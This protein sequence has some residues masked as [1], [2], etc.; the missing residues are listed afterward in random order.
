MKGGHS[1]P[2][3]G[4]ISCR[5]VTDFTFSSPLDKPSESK[6]ATTTS[7]KRPRHSLA[8]FSRSDTL[9]RM[10]ED[11][12]RHKRLRERIWVVPMPRSAFAQGLGPAVAAR[13]AVAKTGMT[14]SPGS[15]TTSS[16]P[17]PF[18]PASPSI[19]QVIQS[20]AV[21]DGDVSTGEGSAGGP[22]GAQNGQPQGIAPDVEFEQAWEDGS[23]LGEDDLN[24]FME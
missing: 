16:G 10:D 11:R 15:P 8:N 23:E 6:I 7:R 24:G 19:H 22:D 5:A 3:C 12:E 18:T 1:K 2:M 20:N 13:H 17:S 21:G 4:V 9:R 14:F